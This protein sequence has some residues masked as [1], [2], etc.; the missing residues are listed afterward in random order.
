MKIGDLVYVKSFELFG[1]IMLVDQ[2]DPDGEDWHQ[3][4]SNG[5]FSWYPSWMVTLFDTDEREA[6]E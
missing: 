5:K 3:L 4:F 1:I 2:E 6:I